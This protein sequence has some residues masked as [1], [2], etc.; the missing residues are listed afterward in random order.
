V[1]AAFDIAG[2]MRAFNQRSLMA[3]SLE[4]DVET[5]RALGCGSLT[6]DDLYSV[7]RLKS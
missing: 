3:R 7:W 4:L 6:E 5:T 1:I 2:F